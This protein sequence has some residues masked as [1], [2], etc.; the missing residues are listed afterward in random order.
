MQ[1]LNSTFKKKK[2]PETSFDRAIAACQLC[3]ITSTEEM[4]TTKVVLLE[5]TSTEH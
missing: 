3:F 5:I 2:K 4:M 1:F